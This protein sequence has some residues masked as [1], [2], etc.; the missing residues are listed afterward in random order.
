MRRPTTAVLSLFLLTSIISPTAT[1][2]ESG[3]G[4]T[5]ETAAADPALERGVVRK[6]QRAADRLGSDVRRIPDAEGI[7]TT[8]IDRHAAR[9]KPD[10]DPADLFSWMQEHIGYEPYDGAIRGAEG[11]L[12]SGRGNAADQALLAAAIFDAAGVETR[13]VVGEAPDQ[14]WE[15]LAQQSLGTFDVEKD[16]KTIE[17]GATLGG[18]RDLQP[19]THVWLEVRDDG[20]YKAFDPV[21][22]KRY[23]SAHGKASSRSDA[24]PEEFRGTFRMQLRSRLQDGQEND[25]LTLSGEL[26]KVSGMNITLEFRQDTAR[27]RYIEPILRRGGKSKRGDKF[28]ADALERLEL[29]FKFEAGG[30]SYLTRKLLYFKGVTPEFAEYDQQNYAI[31]VQPNWVGD[32]VVR[33]VVTSQ[34]GELADK[35]DAWG[36]DRANASERQPDFQYRAK[37]DAFM[38]HLAACLPV[39][40]AHEADRTALALAEA[41]R[42]VPVMAEP[43]VFVVGL[44]RKGSDLSV[45]YWRGGG[46]VIGVGSSSL[47]LALASGLAAITGYNEEKLSH[48]LYDDIAQGRVMGAEPIFEAAQQ[49]H[50]SFGTSHSGNSERLKKTNFPDFFKDTIRDLAVNEGQV[51]LTPMKPV[52]I[53]DQEHLGWWSVS[54]SNDQLLAH[55][56]T[57][58]APASK[59]AATRDAEI[60]AMLRVG[61]DIRS[62]ASGAISN[63]VDDG[64]ICSSTNRA[65]KF[66]RAFCAKQMLQTLPELDACL[67]ETGSD[68]NLLGGLG[69]VSAGPGSR[70]KSKTPQTQCNQQMR[71]TRCGL[72]TAKAVLEGKLELKRLDEAPQKETDSE[73][74]E[75]AAYCE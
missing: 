14:A 56:P 42:I 37:T 9:I 49:R 28:P 4:A 74:S 2:Q 19:K 24:L 54:P 38:S 13:F 6:L 3:E 40:H 26:T 59:S 25:L 52:K 41:L 46:E 5:D 45:D 31:S 67:T 39:L 68:D 21:L 71:R 10:R 66:S 34:L 55:A 47:P 62:L 48:A 16:G 73:D 44:L 17:L 30:R 32:G 1:A 18:W 15:T 27:Q 72:V 60:A 22:S 51:L 61:M 75:P 33:D 12:L 53:G 63:S 36:R 65:L 23:A 29:K 69:N 43:R 11:T 70:S 58:Y 50:L 64:H 8:S 57:T 20:E 7:A 35:I